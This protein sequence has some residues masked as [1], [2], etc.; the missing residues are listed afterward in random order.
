MQREFQ[1]D[2]NLQATCVSARG[3]GLNRIAILFRR[4]GVGRMY[5][6]APAA[7][8]AEFVIALVVAENIPPQAVQTFNKDLHPRPG[9]MAVRQIHPPKNN[10]AAALPNRGAG[11]RSAA[12]QQ[13]Q[14]CQDK[15][16]TAAERDWS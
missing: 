13:R 6:I 7:D 1:I 9:G 3:V 12:E 16:S 14:A 11:D 15:H 8:P 2:V 5:A 10:E 4:V